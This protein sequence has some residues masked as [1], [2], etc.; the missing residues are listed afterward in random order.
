MLLPYLSESDPAIT[1]EGSLDPLGLYPISDRLATRMVPGFRERMQH[2]RF[3]TAIAVGAVICSDFEEDDVAKDSFTPP[4]QVYEWYIIQGLTRVYGDSDENRG[5]NGREKASSAIRDGVPLSAARYLKVPNVFGFHGVYRTLAKDTDL[6]MGDQLG[7]FGDTL[8]RVWEKEQNLQGF[9]SQQAGPGREFRKKLVNAVRDGLEKAAVARSQNWYF[10]WEMAPHFA[11]YQP[12]RKESQTIHRYI[13]NDENST[14]SEVIR[15]LLS[16]EG[17]NVWKN[18]LSEKQFHLAL[19]KSAS[20]NLRKLLT[21][22]QKYEL[23][24]RILQNAFDACLFQMSRC[25]RVLLTDLAKLSEMEIASKELPDL[26]RE[27]IDFIE[28]Y[29]ES[30]NFENAFG[31][32][33]TKTSPLKWLEIF[34]SHH[35]NVQKNK[36]PSGKRPW[37]EK[38]DHGELLIY[39]SYI[40]DEKP[41]NNEEYVNYYRTDPLWSFMKDLRKVNNG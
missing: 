11:I 1:S 13:A 21:V 39:P 41:N 26:T 33:S 34:I 27:I 18:S 32:F 37:F 15:F 9:Y 35:L 7:E 14:R 5:L 6:L 8:V 10:F 16:D 2:P 40:K 24:S 36:T 38:T 20:K 28:P 22:I 12:G 23:F 30:L 17:Q 29:G 31:E 4:Y 3:L 19:F 25:P